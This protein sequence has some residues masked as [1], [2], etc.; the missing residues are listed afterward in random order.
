MVM[1]FP[2]TERAYWTKGSQITSMTAEIYDAIASF[3]RK[4]TMRDKVRIIS[5]DIFDGLLMTDSILL[6]CG[7]HAVFEL[8]GVSS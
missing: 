1:G 8:K 3:I 2:G 6:G 5:A 7:Q 4:A